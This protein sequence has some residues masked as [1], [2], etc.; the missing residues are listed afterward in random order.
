MVEVS[1]WWFYS[2]TR[3]SY[4]SWVVTYTEKFEIELLD[5]DVA[6]L[7]SFAT[8]GNAGDPVK[9]GYKV[10]GDGIEQFLVGVGGQYVPCP[11]FPA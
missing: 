8:R 2:D 11:S 6:E 5:E 4:D 3:V 10:H 7:H 9:H 1:S